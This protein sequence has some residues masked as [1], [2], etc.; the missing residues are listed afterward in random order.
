M[1]KG[2]MYSLAIMGEYSRYVLVWVFWP[3]LAS[4][5]CVDLVKTVLNKQRCQIFSSD[6]GSQ[7]TSNLFT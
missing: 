6:Q 3:T 7:F 2:L 1:Q 5:I 4:D